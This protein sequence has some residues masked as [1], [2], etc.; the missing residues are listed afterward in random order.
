MPRNR[1]ERLTPVQVKMVATRDALRNLVKVSIAAG[2]AADF[3]NG[4]DPH[5]TGDAG[6][7]AWSAYIK[8]SD[9]WN[10]FAFMDGSSGHG[11]PGV[12]RAVEEYVKRELGDAA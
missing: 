7:A 10:H 9:A 2:A 11:W 8:A 1:S 3:S 6:M 5:L 12:L 4:L